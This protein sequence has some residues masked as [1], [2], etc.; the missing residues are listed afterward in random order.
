M[1]QL[2]VPKSGKN[3]HILFESRIIDTS[4]KINTL[5]IYKMYKV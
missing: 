3:A 1:A 5:K 2:L 4:V